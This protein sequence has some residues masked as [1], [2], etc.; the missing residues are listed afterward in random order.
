MSI[1]QPTAPALAA[2]REALIALLP[3][4]AA[5]TARL[6]PGVTLRD[7]TAVTD[8]HALASEAIGT[9]RPD[10]TSQGYLVPARTSTLSVCRIPAL[11]RPEKPIAVFLPGLLSWLPVTA[12]RALAFVDL[13]DVVLCELPGHG[14]SEP[15]AEV[16]LTAFAEEVAGL[17]D[18]ALAR[19]PVV[20]LIGESLGGLVALALAR[21]RP[22]RLRN[23]IL[24][25]VPFQLTRPALAVGI[26]EAWRAA[27]R[28]PYVRRIC[29]E[30]MGFDPATGTSRSLTPLGQ[31]WREARQP[32]AHLL[33]GD[34]LASR[35]ASVVTEG[36][37]ADLRAANPAM[38]IPPRIPN[39]GHAVLLDN[40]EAVTEILRSILIPT[41]RN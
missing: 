33:G 21:I 11:P 17:L 5:D 38:L 10:I 29:N 26:A 35:F 16:S 24:V 32:S 40:P 37:V 20:T 13:F 22:E 6:V 18:T 15:C 12:V 7:R 28:P 4:L 23:I 30:I 14:A 25:D 3:R 1:Q 8:F 27:G 34:N 36:D 9:H 19:A 31:L 39:T 41:G 2:A